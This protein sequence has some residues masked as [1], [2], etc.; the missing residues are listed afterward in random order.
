ME[1]IGYK[2]ANLKNAKN[3]GGV[4]V[5]ES[6]MSANETAKHINKSIEVEDGVRVPDAI[7]TKSLD[8]FIESLGGVEDSEGA[9]K[10]AEMDA[11]ATKSLDV[12]VGGLG[13]VFKIVEIDTVISKSLDVSIGGL[14]GVSSLGGATKSMTMITKR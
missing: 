3:T 7:V 14:G 1:H 11:I 10:I 12:L 8:I 2:P 5:T 9:F 6:R 13:G 4:Y